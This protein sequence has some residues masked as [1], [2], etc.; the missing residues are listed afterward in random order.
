MVELITKEREWVENMMAER[1]LGTRPFVTLCRIARYYYS[2]GHSKKDIHGMLQDYVIRCQ[3]DANL[4]KWE[5]AL[6]RCVK[7]ADRKRLIDIDDIVITKA[8]MATIKSMNGTMLQRLLFTVL[9]LAKYSRAV[10][11]CADGWA[12]MT[13]RD[14]FSLANMQLPI[15]KQH[16]M[17]NDLWREGVIEYNRAIDN[18]NILVKCIDDNSEPELVVSDFRNLGNQYLRYT[19]A[20]LIPCVSCGLI[21]RRRSNRQMY[22]PDCAVQAARTSK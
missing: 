17:I 16:L 4:I 13:T 2:E 9:C 5:S 20:D 19:G 3:P 14:I 18:L 11:E 12:N 15:R 10:N 6:E 22:C 8:E 21:I 7:Q 1:S